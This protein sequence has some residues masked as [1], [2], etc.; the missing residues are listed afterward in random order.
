MIRQNDYS[1]LNYSYFVSFQFLDLFYCL[2]QPLIIVR[3]QLPHKRGGVGGG[4][5]RFLKNGCNGGDGKFLPKIGGKP[6]MGALV[7]VL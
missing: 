5:M 1:L 2:W 3:T 4:E 6:E 7:L